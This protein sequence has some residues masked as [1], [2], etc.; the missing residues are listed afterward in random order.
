METTLAGRGA[1]Q[2]PAT[3]ALVYVIGTYPVPTTT[4]I[5]REIRALRRAGADIRLV[6]LR[7][8]THR[9]SSDQRE[10]ASGNREDL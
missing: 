1:E 5:D 2:R 7:R 10:L 8:P 3:L 4:F 9:L 6:S